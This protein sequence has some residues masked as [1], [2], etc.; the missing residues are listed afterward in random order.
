MPHKSAIFAPLDSEQILIDT[1]ESI[2]AQ[3]NNQR[4]LF[5]LKLS[6]QLANDYFFKENG[7]Q[8]HEGGL[9]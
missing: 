9:S 5:D 6:A 2:N 4:D 8:N 1:K 7:T 3:S